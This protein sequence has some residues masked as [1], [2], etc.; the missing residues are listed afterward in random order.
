MYRSHV[1]QVNGRSMGQ[2]PGS[3][4]V[5]AGNQLPGV[6]PIHLLKLAE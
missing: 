6:D 3:T 4:I 2:L 5:R 1:I